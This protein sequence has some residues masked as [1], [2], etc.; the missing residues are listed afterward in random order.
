MRV[1]LSTIGTRGDVQPMVAL[2][3]GLQAAGHDVL[4][5]ASPDH[6]PFVAER[7]VAFAPVGSPWRQ[8]VVELTASAGRAFRALTGEVAAQFDA[9][10][11]LCEGRDVVVSASLD[12]AT[13]TLCE[14]A[15]V[16][17]VF[18]VFSPCMVPSSSHP[19]PLIA[20]DLGWLNRASWW[21]GEQAGRATSF[22]VVNRERA[23]R[24]LGPVVDGFDY[25]MRDRLV[26][27]CAA[28]LAPVPADVPNATQTGP[29]LL[30]DD[31]PLPDD[32]ERF[33]A[34]GPPPLYVGFGSMP[35]HDAEATTA[36]LAAALRTVGA[37]A[38]VARPP[39]PSLGG[40]D[41]LCV[42]ATNHGALFPRCAG[43]VHHGGAG[44]TTAAAR[45]GVP[46]L[47]VPHEVDQHFHGRRVHALGV[48]PKA[49]ARRKLTTERLVEG[50]R[51]LPACADA[52]R[53]FA[54]TIPTDGVAHGVRVVE[55]I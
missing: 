52:A 31:A 33:L 28:S 2:A 18:V 13:T 47:L 51:A 9:L 5:A 15:A 38:L 42:S 27:P 54:A 1:L 24:G 8:L 4:L 23:K 34:A 48:G 39:H 45:A 43:V 30:D 21:F 46:Q 3:R 25:M 40:D 20:R 10:A 7:G 19:W 12:H 49:I 32:V 50:L 6:A 36:I 55:G 41:V 16:P 53:A 44:T 26:V 37:R 22:R 29:W 35:D 14:K 11:P 17:R